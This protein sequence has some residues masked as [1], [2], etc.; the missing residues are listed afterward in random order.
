[1]G[2]ICNQDVVFYPKT[3]RFIIR[4]RSKGRHVLP[5]EKMEG[6]PNL[7]ITTQPASLKRVWQ[8]KNVYTKNN[9]ILSNLVHEQL[10]LHHRTLTTL[11]Y[12]QQRHFICQ[13]ETDY[14]FFFLCSSLCV[15]CT[16][17]TTEWSGQFPLCFYA[18]A[19]SYQ[20]KAWAVQQLQDKWNCQKC[21]QTSAR[22]F[23][24]SKQ[25]LVQNFLR[26]CSLSRV[27]LNKIVL[28]VRLTVRLYM[29][30]NRRNARWIF[31]LYIGEF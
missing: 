17:K 11:W 28:S 8:P 3:S 24:T 9:P 4:T 1:M 18:E 2:T 6:R 25:I 31:V 22:N 14:L 7:R 16:S 12:W 26:A 5:T 13:V 10:H 21:S 20:S 23:L 15:L 30:H 19:T 29:R 27:G